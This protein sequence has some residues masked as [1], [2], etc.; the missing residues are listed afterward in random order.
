MRY[1]RIIQRQPSQCYRNISFVISS[2][3][4]HAEF[5]SRK[6]SFQDCKFSFSTF[7]VMWFNGIQYMRVIQNNLPTDCFECIFIVVTFLMGKVSNKFL[8]Q[9]IL[10]WGALKSITLANKASYES[11]WND[12]F[13][14][15][16]V[17]IFYL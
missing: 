8:F 2:C 4:F 3:W 15:D 16:E 17:D 6:S 5:Y 12:Y 13:V 1:I 9:F 14:A 7:F 10:H 11:F